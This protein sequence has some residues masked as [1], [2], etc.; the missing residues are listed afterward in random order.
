MEER[1]FRGIL[2]DT[3]Q[4]TATAIRFTNGLLGELKFW[5]EAQQLYDKPQTMAAVDSELTLIMAGP[6]Q[7]GR[8]AAQSL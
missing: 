6:Y 5:Y 2:P 7:K 3:A 8:M 1:A 4:E